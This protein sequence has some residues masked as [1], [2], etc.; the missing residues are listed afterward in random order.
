VAGYDCEAAAADTD[1]NGTVTPGDALAVYEHY[2]AGQPLEV[3]LGQSSLAIA[4]T[5]GDAG[6]PRIAIERRET[7]NA[8]DVSL[9]I[10]NPRGVRAMGFCLEHPIGFE[11]ER[12][13]P[14]AGTRDWVMTDAWSHGDGS[15]FVGGFDTRGTD[16]NGAVELV[17]VRLR[18][19]DANADASLIR[20][21]N[22][23]DDLAG[24]TVTAA[25]ETPVGPV[26]FGL[27]QNHP[28]PFNPQTSIGFDVPAQA[29]RVSVR[30]SVYDVRGQLVR[31][32]VDGAREPGAHTVTWDGRDQRGTAVTSGIYFYR[33]TAGGFQESRRMVLLK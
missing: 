2:L 31:V 9:V 12:L 1:C 29:G 24:A 20:L 33:L 26:V 32:L 4:A 27:H 15:I 21:T 16:A 17:H 7:G 8:V 6:E 5:D 25:D 22:F 28:N 10:R 13:V 11:L 14:A 19:N 30:L 23:V 18:R 3:C